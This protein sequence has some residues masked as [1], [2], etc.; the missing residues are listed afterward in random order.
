MRIS[1]VPVTLCL[2]FLVSLPAAAGAQDAGRRTATVAGRITEAATGQ[3]M[4]GVSVYLEGT[5]SGSVTDSAG[6]FRIANAPPGPQV[7]RAQ[8]IGYS[9]TRASV[10]VPGS[11]SVTRNIQLA[12]HALELKGVQVTADPTSRARGEL[13]T[14]TVIEGEAIRNQTAASLAGI[15]ELTP[16][17]PLQAPGLDNIQQVSL[18]SVPISSGAPGTGRS[19]ENL[20]AF[21]TLIVLDGVPLSN[22][23][24]LQGLGARA[25]LGVRSSAGGGIDLRRIPA[26]TIERVEVIRGVP[27]A[28]FG[29][30]TQG[31]IVVDT[32]AGAVEPA[33]ALRLD[34]STTE[35]SLVGGRQLGSRQSATLTSNFARTRVSGGTR[36]DQATRFAAQLAHRVILG[37]GASG[38]ASMNDATDARLVLDTR[39]NFYQLADI[40]PEI[41]AFAGSES[42][43]RDAGARILERLRLRLPGDS[44]L[45]W[46][47]A[48][49]RGRQRNFARAN[50][51]RGVTPVT[52]RTEPGRQ[53]GRFLGGVYNARATVEGDPTFFYTRAEILIPADV[54]TFAHDFRVGSE[55]K[56]EANH[57]AGVQ[58]DIEFPPQ[59]RFNG[60]RGFDRPRSFSSVPPLATTAFYVDDRM[61]RSFAGGMVLGLQAG[62]RAD[63]LHR[64]GSWFSSARDIVVQPRINAELSPNTW[65]RFRAGAGRLAKSPSLGNLYPAPDFYDVIN[66]NFFANEPSERLGVLTTFIFDPTN[67]DLGYIV[68]DRAEAG[69]ELRLGGGGSNL[70]FTAFAD[71][72][73]KAVGIRAEPTFVTR[74]IFNLLNT[75]PGSGR[76]PVIVEPASRVDSVPVLID[77]PANNVSLRGSGFEFTADFQEIPA[78]RT[79]VA[80]QGALVRSR[81]EKDG[82]EFANSFG[83]FQVSERQLRSPYYESITRTGERFLLNTRLIHQQPE[84]GLVVTGTIQHTLRE[85]RHNVGGT[86]TLAFVGYITRGG[87]LVPVAAAERGRPEFADIRL[88]R[89][90]VLVAPQRGAVDWLFSL[91]VSKTLPR[92]GRLSFYAFNAFDRIGHYGSGTVAPRRYQSNRF[93]L[94]VTMPV[95]GLLPWR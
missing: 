26:T 31:A 85:I 36:N 64:G 66:V 93:G 34:A 15:L 65:L 14:A 83:E 16:G 61:S 18:R 79:R 42:N 60:V 51:V 25:D 94:E 76:P 84:V 21:G 20:A 27:S 92:D 11:G 3:P 55:L 58:F 87:S 7:L 1:F 12:R 89:S 56:R 62:A 13:G 48:Y 73:A 5:R 43:S 28:R 35:T 2:A 17:I 86:D 40:R 68:S 81:L 38:L 69:F 23:A 47:T 63:I 29:D 70:S 88:P 32:R 50:L 74:E 82:I 46:T 24:N 37:P 90:G 95:E 71:R 41:A 80:F 78:L 22:N 9:P 52:N 59:A 4:A 8:R 19:A 6:D 33:V 30:L 45:E 75:A 67:A 53:T 10:V 39:A 44:R 54:A 49:E 57:G 72:T 77:R 91:Q